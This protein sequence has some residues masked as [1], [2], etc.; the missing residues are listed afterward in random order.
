MTLFLRTILG[1]WAGTA[2][3]VVA[4]TATTEVLQLPGGADSGIG[5]GECGKD[6]DCARP[7]HCHAA[8]GACVAC[9][10]DEHCASSLCDD[11]T[12]TC[13]GCTSQSECRGATP[14]CDV[15]DRRCVQCTFSAQC[16]P[17][18][19]C[20]AA[21]HA[22]A[23]RCRENADCAGTNRPICAVAAGVCVECNASTQCADPLPFCEMREGSCVECLVNEDCPDL[24]CSNEKQC[25][26]CS[27]DLDCDLGQ[28]CVAGDCRF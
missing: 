24:H 7:L 1:T 2:W 20:E 3:I 25:H 10:L 4:C 17:N 6:G 22:C 13:K 16:G 18:E 23:A 11:T 5:D 14:R 27:T 21:A 15:D 9:T 8:S 19:V 28:T 12:R 26:T